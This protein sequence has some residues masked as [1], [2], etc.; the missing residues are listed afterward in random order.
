MKLIIYSNINSK[1]KK[2]YNCN[3]LLKFKIKK[4]MIISIKF[5]YFKKIINNNYTAKMKSIIF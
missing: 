5:K 3:N 1:K 2:I 4:L